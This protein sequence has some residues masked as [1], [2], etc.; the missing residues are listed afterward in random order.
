[1]LIVGG[2]ITGAGTALDAAARGLSVGLVEA[3]DWA[4]GTSSR[5]SKLVHGGLRYLEMLDFRLVHEGLRERALLLQRL[6]PHLVHPVPILWPLRRPVLERAYVGAGIALYDALGLSTGTGRG[7]PL[8]RHLSRR[9]T[10]AVAPGLRAEGLA[11]AV[12]YYDGQVDDARYVVEV[13]RTAVSLGATAVNRATAVGFLREG[14][15]VT[16]AIVRDAETGEEAHV[17]ARVTVIATGAWTEETEALA[18][19]HRAVQVRPSKGAHILVPR[20][21]LAL[22]TGL[23]T[24]TDRSVLFVLPWREQWLIGTTDT[25][26][27]YSKARPSCHGG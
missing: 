1:M 3:Q 16:G 12:L 8:H 27:D 17:R 15:Q 10:L 2:G 24:R 19:R 7:L 11:G 21:K 6:A 9:R 26:W 4:S 25:D 22:S 20:A 5:S 23:I 14:Q 13:V 18:G